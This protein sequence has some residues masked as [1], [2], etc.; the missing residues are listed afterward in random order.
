M[1][2]FDAD[3]PPDN[4]LPRAEI[5]AELAAAGVVLK[6][7]QGLMSAP[8]ALCGEPYELETGGEVDH[9][10]HIYAPAFRSV[11][12]V[13][14]LYA[15]TEA[16]DL[17][18]EAIMRVHHQADLILAGTPEPERHVSVFRRFMRWIGRR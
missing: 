9:G 4:T 17:Q 2:E 5:N 12:P 7:N 15:R 8:C 11:K 18:R 14:S 3:A 6:V 16:D 10:D 1:S 13:S